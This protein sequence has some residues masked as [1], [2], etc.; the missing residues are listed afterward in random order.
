MAET[1]PKLY[2]K[3]ITYSANGKAMLYVTLQKALYGCPK[4]A[5][6]FYR[7]LV[8]EITS[9][10]FKLNPY[11]PC[12]ANKTI[13]GKQMTITWHMDDLKISHVMENEVTKI[14]D[15]SKTIYGN[16]R[17]SRGKV[18]DYYLGMNLDFTDKGKVKISMVPFLKKVIE[19][20]PEVITGSA[21]TPAAAH[22]FDVWDD[23]DR[24]I[25]EE[26]RACAFH[27]AMAQLLFATIRY[28]RYVQ[29]TVVFLCTRVR[30]LDK[31]DWGKLKQLLKLKYI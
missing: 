27:P 8:S 25:L 28:R 6:L 13:N 11:D 21:A 18:H 20:F 4:S 24:K 5:L 9:K 23:T 12:V 2:R 30:E 17:V 14:I 16:A 26:D 22:L 15:W 7:K 3:Y 29:T 10:G 31:D 19:D 1:A